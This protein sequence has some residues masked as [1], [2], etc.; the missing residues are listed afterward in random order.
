MAKFEEAFAE[1]LEYFAGDELAANVFVSKYALSNSDGEIE[2]TTPEKMHRR[3]AAE[4]ARIE[5]KYPNPLSEEEIF[6]LLDNSDTI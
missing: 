5:Q 4:F 2:E 3:M 1:S 6:S